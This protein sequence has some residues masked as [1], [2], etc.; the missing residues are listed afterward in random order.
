[1]SSLSAIVLS[2]T[3]PEALVNDLARTV[4]THI[5]GKS[6]ISGT[7]MKLGFG[8]LRSAKPDIAARAARSL[9]P[10]IAKALDPIYDAF[11]SSG[12]GDFGNYLGQ[13]SVKAAA[14]VID[15]V[16]TRIAQ[17]E[18]TTAKA[19]YKRFRGSAGDELQKLLPS[20]GRVLTKHTTTG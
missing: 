4:E 20:L 10:H 18:N 17:S 8:A 15:T 19:V 2:V 11:K 6:G 7:A 13:H 12:S 16:D 5:A 14:L 3:D 1:M 9:L